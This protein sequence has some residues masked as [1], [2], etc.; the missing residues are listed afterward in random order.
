MVIDNHGVGIWCNNEEIIYTELSGGFSQLEYRVI[1]K[2]G[3]MA[4]YLNDEFL[5]H[6]E[7][8]QYRLYRN[9]PPMIN[10][11][12]WPETPPATQDTAGVDNFRVWV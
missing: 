8:D 5:G 4:F 12:T 10:V 9:Y 7:N 11:G 3:Q 2:G 1:V 6:Y